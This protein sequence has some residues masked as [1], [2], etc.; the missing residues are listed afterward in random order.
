MEIVVDIRTRINTIF[1]NAT[2]KSMMDV[3]KWKIENIP[4]ETVYKVLDWSLVEEKTNGAKQ[5]MVDVHRSLEQ[6]INNHNE[7]MN[8]YKIVAKFIGIIAEMESLRIDIDAETQYSD[9]TGELRRR[10]ERANEM[11]DECISIVKKAMQK[12]MEKY[13]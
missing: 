11:L 7:V 13:E 2:P 12:E 1:K 3:V 5:Q 6:T 8:S 9:P 4:G 10:Y